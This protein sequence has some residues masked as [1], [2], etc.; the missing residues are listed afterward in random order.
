M[1]EKKRNIPIFNLKLLVIVWCAV[2]VTAIICG[3][4][5]SIYVV[6]KL[7]KQE[8]QR[9]SEDLSITSEN[10]RAYTRDIEDFSINVITGDLQNMLRGLEETESASYF[11]ILR[12]LRKDL[13]YYV[14]LRSAAIADMYIVRG[15][16]EIIGDITKD[17]KAE[18]KW[19]QEY[20]DKNISRGFST[21]IEPESNL[22]EEYSVKSFHY[23][24]D[25][26]DI[27][28]SNKVLGKL[29][30]VLDYDFF[31]STTLLETGQYTSVILMDQDERLMTFTINNKK[32]A[33]KEAAICR[34]ISKDEETWIQ[35]QNRY[36]MRQP[37]KAVG[38]NLY[39]ILDKE[40]ITQTLNPVR[41]ILGVLVLG[42][43]FISILIFTPIIY[44]TTEPLKTII[45]GME[46]VSAGDLETKIFVKTKDE[47]SAMADIF[48]HMMID[49]RTFLEIS[50]EREKQENELRMKLFMAQINP[51]FICN[52]LNV[53]IYQAQKIK[54]K[55][56]IEVTRAFINIIQITIN[57]N[58][59][60]KSKIREEKKY[61]EDYMLINRYRYSDIVE[62]VW[63][64]EEGIMECRINRMILYPLVENSMV[65]GI[66]PTGKRGRIVITMIKEGTWVKISVEDNGKGFTKERLAEIRKKIV[67]EKLEG[68]NS[69][70]MQNVNL[71]L[72]LIYGADCEMKIES[73]EGMGSKISFKIPEEK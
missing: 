3:L 63:Q 62:L 42:C 39:G 65:H 51:H 25:I 15:E 35:K 49:I 9:A 36:Y 47:L 31:I 18:E 59:T 48:N 23:V 43:L 41:K 26:V 1:D 10:I 12:E 53:I 2:I 14:A 7:E 54:A 30:L 17:N 64:V 34:Q 19:Y 21:V 45:R 61:I 13:K 69:I 5:L 29:V 50:V 57:L 24:I 22:R 73:R 20:L 37:V 8:L 40:E 44:M 11:K 52:T 6:Q 28:N 16:K 56:I 70:G 71:R 66:F 67:N 72:R 32:T 55:N 38:W 58:H 4:S 60:V 33:D 68:R 27:N 46:K